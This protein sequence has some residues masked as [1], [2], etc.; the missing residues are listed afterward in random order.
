MLCP[1][2]CLTSNSSSHKN[3]NHGPIVDFTEL[4]LRAVSESLLELIN[5][6]L[7]PL[8]CDEPTLVDL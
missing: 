3:E 8:S 6:V 4:M 7:L 5:F 1:F 2:L